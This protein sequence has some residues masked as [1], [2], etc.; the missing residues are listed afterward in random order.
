MDRL[1][2]LGTQQQVALQK[3]PASSHSHWEYVD[4]ATRPPVTEAVK[5]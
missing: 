2:T 3:G 4:V 1:Q 5:S